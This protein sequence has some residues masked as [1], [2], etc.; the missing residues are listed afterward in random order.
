MRSILAIDTAGPEGSVALAA[1]SRPVASVSL[2]PSGHSEALA[3]AA[4]SL[5]RDAGLAFR[6]LAALAVAEGPGSFT[7]LRIGLAWAKGVAWGAGVPLVLV[8]SHEA[9]AFAHAAPGRLVASLIPGERGR[10]EAALWS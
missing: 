2:P 4:A 10:T 1:G 7:G 6:D 8:P 5:L 9:L 3:E